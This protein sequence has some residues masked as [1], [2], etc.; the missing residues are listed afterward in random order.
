[1]TQSHFAFWELLLTIGHLVPVARVGTDEEPNWVST[2][3]LRNS[4]KAHWALDKLGWTLAPAG[5]HTAWD[6]LAGWFVDYLDARPELMA[7]K[8]LARWFRA[9]V[10]MRASLQ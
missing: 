2:S 6:G 5:D 9:T 3:M 8:Y 7:D 1:M 4:A 10:E